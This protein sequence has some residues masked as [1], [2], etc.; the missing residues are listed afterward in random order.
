MLRSV[1][2]YYDIIM[3]RG[4]SV[5]LGVVLSRGYIKQFNL[6]LL[7]TYVLEIFWSMFDRKFDKNLLYMFLTKFNKLSKRRVRTFFIS[8]FKN[9]Q[10]IKAWVLISKT[11]FYRLHLHTFLF[12]LWQVVWSTLV[13]VQFFFL[14]R[15]QNNVLGVVCDV[16]R[17]KNCGWHLFLTWL[18]W[19]FLCFQ[20]RSQRQREVNLLM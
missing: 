3:S 8:Q 17:K 7:H 5:F 10:N 11:L 12:Y 20:N 18:H 15:S 4:Y 14:T 19:Y 13:S 6:H 1:R 16:Y 9:K 2:F